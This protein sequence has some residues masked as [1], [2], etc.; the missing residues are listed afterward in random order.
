MFYS[1]IS[2]RVDSERYKGTS[3]ITRVSGVAIGHFNVS[4]IA[5]LKAVF[6][7]ALELQVPVVG[8]SKGDRQFIGTRQIAVLVYSLREQFDFPVFLNADLIRW[9]PPLRR[10]RVVLM[11]L[12]SMVL[13]SRLSI[14]YA[15][16]RRQSK[17]F[18]K[19]R[20]LQVR[21]PQEIAELEAQIALD[22]QK[23]REIERLEAELMENISR[24]GFSAVSTEVRYRGEKEALA[25]SIRV[26]E[27]MLAGARSQPNWPHE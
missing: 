10:P 20:K 25:N 16:C 26:A 9:R 7:S 21:D 23:Y 4:D 5:L 11:P 8:V 19:G 18:D 12:H 22:K 27:E 15:R 17:L 6:S 1:S 2:K 13:H 24:H 14:I 3:D